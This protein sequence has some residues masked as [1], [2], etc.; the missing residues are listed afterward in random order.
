MPR[1]TVVNN[2]THPQGSAT[3]SPTV[4][5]LIGMAP[6]TTYSLCGSSIA[7][8]HAVQGMTQVP[9]LA[10]LHTYDQRR[11]STLP[12]PTAGSSDGYC[13]S[14]RAYPPLWL[15]A[16]RA[17]HV[18][19]DACGTARARNCILVALQGEE[20]RTNSK[21]WVLRCLSVHVW[22]LCIIRM[23]CTGSGRYLNAASS[24]GR[25]RLCTACQ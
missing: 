16:T 13:R 24:E 18:V 14:M 12:L 9:S 10:E 1:L 8:H 19:R 22:L 20:G 25:D 5:P 11:R 21:L 2:F 23:L 6:S 17:V 3:S 15:R 7:H 4:T